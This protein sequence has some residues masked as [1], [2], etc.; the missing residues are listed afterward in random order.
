[1]RR[2]NKVVPKTKGAGTLA[3]KKPRS[4]PKRI[5]KTPEHRE[6][7]IIA[8]TYDLAERQIND[9]SVSSQVMTH[10]LK[11]G[12]V[13]AK[14]ELERLRQ[15]NLLLAAKTDSLKSAKRYE[16]LVTK[17][18]EALMKYGRANIVRRDDS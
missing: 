14:L 6:A 10:F 15:E 18:L 3:E 4:S 17:G 13:L 7:A 8:K 11:Q 12:T 16:E 5:S 1:L 2:V 9:G